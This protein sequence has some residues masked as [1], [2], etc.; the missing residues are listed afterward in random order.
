MKKTLSSL[1]AFV[2]ILSI[3]AVSPS[4]V[5][6]AIPITAS[7]ASKTVY[8][9][10]A[11]ATLSMRK[12]ASTSYAKI[13]T[14]PSGAEVTSDATARN[15]YTKV[16]YKQSGKSYIGWVL[17]QYLKK[18]RPATDPARVTGLRASSVGKTSV[19]LSWSKATDATGYRVYQYLKTEKKYVLIK[20]TASTGYT[21]QNLKT[22]TSYI[23][24]V[25]AYKKSGNKTYFG[26]MSSQLSVK[27]ASNVPKLTD[28]QATSLYLKADKVAGDW[29]FVDGGCRYIDDDSPYTNS[30]YGYYYINHSSIKSVKQLKHYLSKYFTK[31][32]YEKTVD[33]YYKDIGGKL[34]YVSDGFGVGDATVFDLHR[35]RVLSQSGNTAKLELT[36]KYMYPDESFWR[37]KNF[38]LK[39]IYKNGTWIFDAPF[40]LVWA[41]VKIPCI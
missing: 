37:Y 38:T 30:Y 23:F 22:N 7:A 35:M 34:F 8:V 5:K 25:R 12:G 13:I 26:K 11:T 40:Y 9:Y 3:A 39:A 18:L 21:V 20:S 14:V 27:T 17:S 29:L 33:K 6:N 4:A 24:S 15:N 36:V 32:V 2:L 10:R 16:T 41:F 19:K 1:L 31:S 28:K